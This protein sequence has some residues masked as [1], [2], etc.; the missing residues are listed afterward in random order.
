MRTRPH[1]VRSR[2]PLLSALL[3]CLATGCARPVARPSTHVSS[4][5]VSEL[6]RS[7]V[8]VRSGVG[9]GSGVVIEPDLVLT[10]DHV[11]QGADVENHTRWVTVLP[12]VA[13]PDGIVPDATPVRGYVVARDPEG[14]VALVRL[15]RALEGV[16]P[17]EVAPDD[18]RVGDAVAC[19][20][21]GR[22]HLL[23]STRRGYVEAYGSEEVRTLR[24]RAC[25]RSRALACPT[26]RVHL[27]EMASE[28]LE[29]SCRVSG[30]D[31]GGPLVDARGRL[32][33]IASYTEY[34]APG[35][36][37]A[38]F[39]HPRALRRMLAERPTEPLSNV[40]TPPAPPARGVALDLD[41][42]GAWESLAEDTGDA[43]LRRTWMDLDG[44]SSLA[45]DD[46]GEVRAT[47]LAAFEPELVLVEGD[48]HGTHLFVD[49]NEDGELDTLVF[50]DRRTFGARG[51][52][53]RRGDLWQRDPSNESRWSGALDESLVGPAS[54]TRWARWLEQGGERPWEGPRPRSLRRGQLEDVDEDGRPDTLVTVDRDV[55]YDVLWE[56][57]A[58]DVDQRWP[59][60]SHLDE[61]LDAPGS[62]IDFVAFASPGNFFRLWY[63]RDGDGS[64]ETV[65]DANA[66]GIV[67]RAERREDGETQLQDELV[68]TLVGRPDFVRRERARARAILEQLLGAERIHHESGF[69]IG[70][71]REDEALYFDG[72]ELPSGIFRGESLVGTVY[73]IDLE[74]D[75]LDEPLPSLLEDAEAFVFVGGQATRVVI[76]A[77][78]D[79]RPELSNLRLVLPTGDSRCWSSVRVG[80]R[81]LREPI[82]CDALLDLAALQSS[83]V[84]A[85]LQAKL[86]SLGALLGEENP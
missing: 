85:P 22:G 41:Q 35:Y 40:P 82:A 20:G 49:A 38:Y 46:G 53:R 83:R 9:G 5:D 25:V 15:E 28:V 19:V 11:I 62:G 50:L 27:G 60:R 61:A 67:T 70:V 58:V 12:P 3:V 33:G 55:R 86:H 63:D 44:S 14:D 1:L 45:L 68:G 75:A 23:W 36:D 7:V 6:Y 78:R 16:T 81:Y 10:A 39:V 73:A 54:R 71:L 77:D 76:D 2:L 57:M 79:G 80:D 47:S 69:D 29:T 84:R 42:D 37:V 59:G 43:Y 74:G 66:A 48:D 72:H 64:F 31:S 65:L 24:D 32:V 18:P 56:V 17:L 34:A 51:V 8:V 30:G 13:T 26:H 52:F 21:H 4:F